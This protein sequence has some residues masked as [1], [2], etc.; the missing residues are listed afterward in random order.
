MM[1]YC[2]RNVVTNV[3]SISSVKSQKVTQFPRLNGNRQSGSSISVTHHQTPST[4]DVDCPVRRT[5]QIAI[6]HAQTP[7]LKALQKPLHHQGPTCIDF[8]ART[9]CASFQLTTINLFSRRRPGF[10]G[11]NVVFNKTIAGRRR[12]LLLNTNLVF[13]LRVPRT[14]EG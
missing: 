6:E 9:Q 10:P 14:A 11:Q 13:L 5:Q 8:V 4:C 1:L 12:T 2:C 7:T 3:S